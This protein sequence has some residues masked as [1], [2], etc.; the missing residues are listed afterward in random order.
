MSLSE[1]AKVSDDDYLMSKSDDETLVECSAM[2]R[3]PNRGALK[4]NPKTVGI[5]TQ[6]GVKYVTMSDEEFSNLLRK[7]KVKDQQF[8][9][10]KS[11]ETYINIDQIIYITVRESA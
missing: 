9:F 8:V 4:K 2:A 10:V 5:E 3:K 1:F 11:I 7:I 6:N